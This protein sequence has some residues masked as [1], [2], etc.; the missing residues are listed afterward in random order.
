MHAHG[1]KYLNISVRTL[2]SHFVPMP[3]FSMKA[4]CSLKQEG[5]GEKCYNCGKDFN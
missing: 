2:F 4:V 5:P 1:G 3:T